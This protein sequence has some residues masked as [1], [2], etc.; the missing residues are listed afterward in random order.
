MAVKTW[1]LKNLPAQIP[2]DMEGTWELAKCKAYGIEITPEQMETSM[3]FV[4]NLNGTAVLYTNDMA[5]AGYRLAQK[6]EGVW[7]L[8]SGGVTFYELKYD[9]ATLTLG[10]MG[11]DMIFE[12][13]ED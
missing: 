13:D 10:Y 4:L 9:G 5:P 7:T 2:E 1:E 3:T 12:Q 11:V 8:S 6:E